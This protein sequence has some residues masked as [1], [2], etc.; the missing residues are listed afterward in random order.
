MASIAEFRVAADAFPLGRVFDYLPDA[1]IELERV[2]PTNEGTFPYFWVRGGDAETVSDV[3]E[4]DSAL[5]SVTVV[6]DLDH[7]A[8]FR[9][10]W[11]EDEVGVVTAIRDVGVTLLSGV[12]TVE[13]WSFEIRAE[14]ADQLSAFQAYCRDN[15]VPMTLRRL[16]TLAEMQTGRTYDLSPEQHEALLLAFDEGY[17]DESRE[18]TL[19]E[20][21]GR[22][23]ISRT[24]FSNRLRRGYRNLIGSTIDHQ[25]G[26]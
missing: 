20:L 15:D 4:D 16:H 14:N 24:A 2:V 10:Q 11:D 25:R 22:L 6:D 3:I 9:A 19:E 8:L 7:H 5:R 12:G 23:G 18:T 17:Y 1:R 26:S 21:A 13:E